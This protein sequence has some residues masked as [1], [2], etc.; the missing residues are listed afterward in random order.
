MNEE[1]QGVRFVTVFRGDEPPSHPLLSELRHWCRMFH[2]HGL[3]PP[4]PGGSSGNLSFRAG[5]SLII[6]GTAIGLKDNLADD[7]FVEVI[8]CDPASGRVEARGRREPSSET[9]LHALLYRHF[10]AIGAV[11]HGHHDTITS[12]A[13][14]LGIPVSPSPLPY[15]SKELAEAALTLAATSDFFVLREHGFVAL[16]GDMAK[17]GALCFARLEKLAG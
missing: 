11:F 15:G 8:A 16:G 9:L 12:Q 7:A 4:Y 14:T 5:S 3:A 13:E 2:D 1:Y 17:A 10:P 6:T